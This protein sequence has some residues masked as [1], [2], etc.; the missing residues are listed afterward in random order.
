MESWKISNIQV[1]WGE[2]APCEHLV[3]FYEN[4]RIFLNTL[5][6]FAGSGILAGE[7]VIVIATSRHL[8]SLN[9]RLLAQGFNLEDLQEANKYI[10]IEVNEVFA[11]IL[12]NGWLDET[13]FNTYVVE[14]I[15]RAKHDNSN[16]RA[17][18]ELVAVL[19]EQG[20]CGT[21]VQL[22]HLW[23]KLY[24]ELKFTLYCAYPKIGFTQSPNDSID[25]ICKT[26]SK[27]MDGRAHPSTEIYY[28]SA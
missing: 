8:Q 18:G 17:F 14:L 19:W 4:D 23:H 24:H 12:V 15:N 20:S 27:I 26:H 16:V 25:I 9:E 1:F 5:E 7:S 28:K 11:K 3:Q 2:I 10:P 22:E 21:T 6:G 13:A